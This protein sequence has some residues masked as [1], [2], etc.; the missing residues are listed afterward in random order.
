M[1]KNI[2]VL[3]VILAILSGCTEKGIINSP[4]LESTQ[5]SSDHITAENIFNDLEYI[6]EEGLNASEK[7]SACPFYNVL[8]DTSLIIDYGDVNCL[9]NGKQRR[10]KINIIYTGNYSDSLSVITATLDNYHISNKLVEGKIISTNQGR[11]SNGNIFFTINIDSARIST[12][13]G[14]IDWQS[15]KI[16]EWVGGQESNTIKDNTYK[17]T[18]SSIG[19]AANG[20]DFTT[21]TIDTLNM[22]YGCMPYCLIKSGSFTIYPKNYSERFINYGDNL[23]DCNYMVVIDG[24]EHPIVIEN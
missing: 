2:L 5:T 7:K 8:G 19:N 20:N 12:S 21:Q 17:I 13:N 6:I 11:N 24:K 10:G 23:C 15:T 4:D 3:S 16:K 18:V 9:D 22:D 14:R 1:K